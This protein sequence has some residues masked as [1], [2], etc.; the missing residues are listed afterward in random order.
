MPCS[1]NFIRWF[2]CVVWNR[3]FDFSIQLLGRVVAKT[4]GEPDSFGVRINLSFDNL[5]LL[6]ISIESRN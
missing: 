6:S 4:A 3:L 5:Y 2:S 1:S